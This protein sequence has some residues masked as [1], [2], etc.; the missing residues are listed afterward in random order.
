MNQKK[1]K[2]FAIYQGNPQIALVLKIVLAV[3]LLAIT[4]ILLYLFNT[5]LFP[6]NDFA[7]ISGYFFHGLRFDLSA[8]LYA[9]LPIILLLLL[10]FRFRHNRSYQIFVNI[11]FVIINAVLLIPN[12][13]D[14][15]YY[16]FTMKRLTFDIF[17]YLT[18]GMDANLAGQFLFDFWFIFILWIALIIALAFLAKR[19]IIKPESPVQGS[20]WYYSGQGLTALLISG[21]IVIGMRGGFQLKPVGILSAGEYAEAQNIPLVVNSAFTIMKTI[22]QKG[23]DKKT[24]FTE[25]EI[26]NHFTAEKNYSTQDSLGHTV[27]MDRKNVVIIIL[28]SFSLEH[29]GSLNGLKDPLSGFTPFLDSL[30]EQSFVAA[31]YA[32]GKR[33][34]EGIPAILGSLPTWMDQDFISS[35]YASD[36]T[37]SLASL[38]RS[39]KYTTAF[40]HGG[41]NGTMGF[42]HYSK[43][44]GFQQY[45]GRNEYSNDSD[46]DGEWGIWD[47]PFLQYYARKMNGMQQPFMTTVFTLSSHHPYKVPQKYKGRF[48]TGKL[49]IQQTIMYSDH[50]LKEFFITASKMDWYKNTIFVITADHTSEAIHPYFQSQIGQYRI[51]ILFFTPDT[52]LKGRYEGILQQTDIM[53]SILDYLHFPG[54]FIAFG[55]S[56]F[57]QYEAR[58]NLTRFNGN[59]QFIS[60]SYVIHWNGEK[61]T[62]IYNFVKDS[63]LKENIADASFPEKEG[64]VNTMKAVIQEYNN[65]M[66]ENKLI[67]K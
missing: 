49:P 67:I 6:G 34:I 20:F 58:F 65:R 26:I 66:I 32:N 30:S 62:S 10:P 8:A 50:A 15:I 43:I 22:E 46:Y 23:L 17:S 55:S 16:R 41:N 33:S 28:E 7:S 3:I 44:S 2:K 64:I 13:V 54:K 59:Y 47:E 24:Y 40:F 56:A 63:A 11:S 14:L 37:N 25:K 29:M 57:R 1:R 18:V 52:T 48:R 5:G 9:N 38:L 35:M 42:D 61:I 19:I 60:G 45:H 12:L 39:E 31:G 27:P 36:Q 21:A 4:R 53:P 51:P